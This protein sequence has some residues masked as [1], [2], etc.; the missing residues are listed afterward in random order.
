MSTET[1]KIK[2]NPFMALVGIFSTEHIENDVELSPELKEAQLSADK[3]MNKSS[4]PINVNTGK[5]N[6]KSGFGNKINPKTQ[7]AMRAMH[8]KVQS[9]S[10]EKEEEKER[11]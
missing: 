10:V 3:K 11:E 8:N 6:K 2:I 1:N 5:T 9:A 4:E 7:E